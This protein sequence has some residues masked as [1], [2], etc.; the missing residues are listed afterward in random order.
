M[1]LPF[2]L[3]QKTK[4]I[5]AVIIVITVTA[6]TLV[7][8]YNK[9]TA[10]D[11]FVEFID[12]GQGD[13]T[14]IHSEGYTALIDAGTPSSATKISTALKNHNINTIDVMILSHPHDDHIGSAQFILEEFKVKNVLFSD[15]L[16]ADDENAE[17]LKNIID[18][19]EYVNAKCHY[20]KEGMI[21]NIGNFKMTVLMSDEQAEDENNL[22]IILM[23]ENCD[24][25][26]LFTGDAEEICEQKL[27]AQNIDF[28][29]DV[30]K[31][32]HHGSRTSTSQAFIDH[33]T[34]YY[35]VISCGANNRYGHPH[36]AVVKR[37]ATAGVTMLRT[38]REGNITF[39]IIGGN[40]VLE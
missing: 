25:K 31:V 24:N 33:A 17:A 15:V 23:A 20:A 36:A 13:S 26:F 32:G 34:P 4:I 6:L 35:A 9:E 14:I 16:P 28:D 12:V 19:A 39:K 29:C 7:K 37:L 18:T 5:L 22:S 21:I 10:N 2:K 30:L 8:T 11:D 40:L 38:D 1:S 27:I 3:S